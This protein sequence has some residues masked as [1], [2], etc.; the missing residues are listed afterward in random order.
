MMANWRKSIG[1][2]G[3]LAVARAQKLSLYWKARGWFSW[4]RFQIDRLSSSLKRDAETL[5]YTGSVYRELFSISL[6]GMIASCLFIALAE[7]AENLVSPAIAELTPNLISLAP[8]ASDYLELIG[9]IGAVFLGIYFATFGIIL[10][11][12]Y[13][14]IR[15]DVVDLIL[16]EKVNNI[17]SSYLINLTI[18]CLIS[19]SLSYLGYDTGYLIFLVVLL[20]GLIAILC[21]FQLGK[22]LFLFFDVSRLVDAEIL[23][24]IT[25]LI[26]EVSQ[27]GRRSI[28][29]DAHRQKVVAQRLSTLRYLSFSSTKSL[30][31]SAK[32]NT[33]VDFA[34]ASLL[35][36]Y[37]TERPK[38]PQDSYWFKRK[39]KHPEWFFEDDS[40]TSMAL[41]TDMHLLP[42]EDIDARWF[43]R[44]LLDG[45][46]SSFKECLRQ[47]DYSAAYKTL[48][49]A[50]SANEALASLLL[51]GEGVD[52]LERFSQCLRE[53]EN[54]PELPLADASAAARF[55]EISLHLGLAQASYMFA[56]EYL[57]SAILFAGKLPTVT[58]AIDWKKPDFGKFPSP[59][60]ARLQSTKIRM[61]FETT[62]EGHALMPSRYVT[63][64]VAQD[65]TAAV[66]AG[67]DRIL[68]DV[69]R[70]TTAAVANLISEKREYIA[71]P[72]LLSSFRSATQFSNFVGLLESNLD[73]LYRLEIY[74]EYEIG[75]VDTG[76]AKAEFARLRSELLSA[77]C[78]RPIIAFLAS[79]LGETEELPD[80]FGHSYFMLA[81]ECFKACRENQSKRFKELFLAFGI[82][83]QLAFSR[84]N[85]KKGRVSDEYFLSLL[86]TIAEDLLA[87]TGYALVFSEIYEN[88]DL[89]SHSDD[90]WEQLLQ[91]AQDR[92]AH[93]RW[94]IGI[95]S[96]LKASFFG[97]PRNLIRT[98]WS[99][100][101]ERTLRDLGF[102][103]GMGFGRAGRQH[104]SPI[105]RSVAG[106]GMNQPS[107]AGIYLLLLDKI[108][109]DFDLPQSV[110]NFASGYNRQKD[111]G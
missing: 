21:I 53:H 39:W 29:L 98:E 43:E 76:K 77:L 41:Q 66:S 89:K 25:R 10:S 101:L 56:Y 4:L 24:E 11:S 17:Y 104:P 33:R 51:A 80:Y 34:Y 27:P 107:E 75:K 2:A 55:E 96:A 91:N 52:F 90:V 85:D 72:I 60:L 82:L 109:G 14:R 61:Q 45:L 31:Q 57:R 28:H 42:K 13:S 50:Q 65:F 23:P 49:Y 20:G 37:A 100:Q 46:L 12:T 74:P 36:F 95:S 47:G 97:A 84:F 9:Q 69:K 68:E 81:E 93:L 105:V 16:R 108:E 15:N 79:D 5:S 59:L 38:I 58:E 103:D 92:Q 1:P 32:P 111:K 70:T 3:N 35:R 48:Q 8:N 22:R 102:D 106:I 30:G 7:F 18:L 78:S 86:G 54:A 94:I 99:M 40:S 83:A 6:K 64:L 19:V 26:K 63:Q 110:E 44:E 71:T 62:V 67:L 87:L 73:A 88:P